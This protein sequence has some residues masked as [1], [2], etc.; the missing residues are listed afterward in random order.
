VLTVAAT[1]RKKE[2]YHGKIDPLGGQKQPVLFFE[3]MA[4]PDHAPIG[5]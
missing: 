5:L 3:A 2:F 4:L 1:S